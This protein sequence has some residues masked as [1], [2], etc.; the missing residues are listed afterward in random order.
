MYA[1]IFAEFARHLCG[2][3]GRDFW[4]VGVAPDR[5]HALRHAKQMR[6]EQID[7]KQITTK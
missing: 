6:A 4:G 2:P 7:D 3:S 5:P 1:S